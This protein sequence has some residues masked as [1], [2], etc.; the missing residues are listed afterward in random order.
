[1]SWPNA[2]QLQRRNSVSQ[3]CLGVP[4]SFLLVS[5][6]TLMVLELGLDVLCS[7]AE[8]VNEVVEAVL[9]GQA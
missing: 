8:K 5:L 3:S 4:G 7:E 9:T 2:G 6:P 1:M